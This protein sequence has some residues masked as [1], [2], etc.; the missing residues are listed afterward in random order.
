MIGKQTFIYLQCVHAHTDTHFKFNT[1]QA[2]ETGIIC[3]NQ[4]ERVKGISA[5]S[6]LNIFNA[7]K[8]WNLLLLGS[9]VI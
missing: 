4:I 1:T 8:R 9:P 2:I 6:W 3:L 7:E 5:T